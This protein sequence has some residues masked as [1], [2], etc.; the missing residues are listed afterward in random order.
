MA[1]RTGP[2]AAAIDDVQ[3]ALVA[4]RATAAGADRILAE[5][6]SG[7]HAA[8]VHGIDRLAAVAA[9]IDDAASGPARFATDNALAAREFQKLLIAKQREVLAVVAEGH[10]LDEA[11]RA[12]LE[13][14]AYPG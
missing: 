12:R 6:L 10:R 13:S 2:T 7:A 9:E 3:A 1:E 8:T 4:R 11:S 5:T 14:L